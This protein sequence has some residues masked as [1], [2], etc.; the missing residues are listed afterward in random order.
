[1]ARD[2]P[3][4]GCRLGD[5]RSSAGLPDGRISCRV[6]D[7]K[8]KDLV[9]FDAKVNRIRV[10]CDQGFPDVVV[11]DGVGL[12][13]GPDPGQHPAHGRNE[14][15][16]LPGATNFVPI[17]GIVELGAG[18]PPEDDGTTHEANRA[19]ASAST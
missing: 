18:D 9:W 13:H 8:N 3:I 16:P 11:N 2:G 19:I 12:G 6:K 7:G 5:L 17:G 14:Q 1:M 10:A 15:H 4:R